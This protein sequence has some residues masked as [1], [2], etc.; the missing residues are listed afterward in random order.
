M[1]ETSRGQD[2][3]PGDNNNQIGSSNNSD[4]GTMS[5]VI[6]SI[7]EFLSSDHGV[8]VVMTSNDI[9]QLPPELTR[10]G[11]LDATWYFGLP[12]EE[13][14]E[15]IF[16][17]HFN[18]CN[19]EVNND[20]LKYAAEITNGFTGAEIKETVKGTLR[21]AYN[22]FKKDGNNEITKDD[23]QKACVE[24]IPISKSSR[25]K[26]VLLEEYARNRARHSNKII[27][28]YGCNV[29]NNKIKNTLLSIKDLR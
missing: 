5:R 11:R 2:K 14:R 29:S 19:R 23:L 13:E 27:N 22:R 1:K 18:K 9:S 17:I 4:A 26:I 28:E 8:F 6:G 12:T 3:K 7:L 15:E 10:A 24:I 20:L 25:E 16:K 21:K